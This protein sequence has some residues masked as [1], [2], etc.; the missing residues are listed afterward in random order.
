M[1]SFDAEQSHR[2][3]VLAFVRQVENHAVLRR[4][5]EPGILRQFL[6]QLPGLPAGIAQREQ[7]PFRSAP[8]R[9]GAQWFPRLVFDVAR[10]L[11]KQVDFQIVGDAVRVDRDILKSTGDVGG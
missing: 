11:G 3:F 7:S 9:D 4:H 1:Y 5:R 8:F 2:R 10:K 6:F